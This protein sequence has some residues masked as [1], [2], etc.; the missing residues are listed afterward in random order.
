MARRYGLSEVPDDLDERPVVSYD[1]R[2]GVLVQ[3][4]PDYVGDSLFRPTDAGGGAVRGLQFGPDRKVAGGARDVYNTGRRAHALQQQQRTLDGFQSFVA[5]FNAEHPTGWIDQ[6]AGD[7][8]FAP[9]TVDADRAAN[10]LQGVEGITYLEDGGDDDA[11]SGGSSASRGLFESMMAHHRGGP[12]PQHQQQQFRQGRGPGQ[13]APTTPGPSAPFS[14]S[15]NPGSAPPPRRAMPSPPPAPQQRAQSRAGARASGIQDVDERREFMEFARHGGGA[16]AAGGVAAEYEH[17]FAPTSQGVSA[18]FVPDDFRTAPPSSAWRGIPRVDASLLPTPPPVN[19][20]TAP[21]AEQVL[22]ASRVQYNDHYHPGRGS[23]GPRQQLDTLRVQGRGAPV[24]V[25]EAAVAASVPP[26]AGL[27]GPFDDLRTYDDEW[28]ESYTPAPFGGVPSHRFEGH[29][30]RSVQEEARDAAAASP[31]TAGVAQAMNP[32]GLVPL[33]VVNDKQT[34]QSMQLFMNA[35]PPPDANY[36][37]SYSNGGGSETMYLRKMGL[38]WRPEDAPQPTSVVNRIPNGPD[39]DPSVARVRADQTARA[40]LARS[41]AQQYATSFNNEGPIHPLSKMYQYMEDRQPQNKLGPFGAPIVRDTPYIVGTRSGQDARI[42]G[43]QVSLSGD[44]AADARVMPVAPSDDAGPAPLRAASSS[45]ASASAAGGARGFR[46]SLDGDADL[47]QPAGAPTGAFMPDGKDWTSHVNLDAN[48]VA[49]GLQRTDA[50]QAY[51]RTAR[52]DRSGMST[53]H[54]SAP[55]ASSLPQ[56][57]GDRVRAT[58]NDGRGARNASGSVVTKHTSQYSASGAAATVATAGGSVRRMITTEGRGTRKADGVLQGGFVAPATQGL[59]AVSTASRILPGDAGAHA[60]H[61]VSA[62]FVAS[63]A[64]GSSAPGMDGAGRRLTSY[65]RDGSRDHGVAS[66]ERTPLPVGV[67]IATGGLRRGAG[68]DRDH[69]DHAVSAQRT[70]APS[71]DRSVHVSTATVSMATARADHATR[72]DRAAAGDRGYAHDGAAS[73]ALAPTQRRDHGVASDRYAVGDRGY[74]HDGAASRALAPT[75]RRDHGV[76][77]D[78]Y[79]VGDRGYSHDGAASRA[80]AP[81]QRRDHAVATD[82][83]AHV[84]ADATRGDGAY[85][86]QTPNVYVADPRSRVDHG[87]AASRVSFASGGTGA[88]GGAVSLAHSGRANAQMADRDGA[89][90]A[91]MRTDRATGPRVDVQG[92]RDPQMEVGAAAA[93]PA[94]VMETA[95]GHGMMMNGVT[96][97]ARAS[98]EAVHAQSMAD[99]RVSNASLQLGGGEAASRMSFADPANPARAGKGAND[100]RTDRELGRT[101]QREPA[102]RHQ[103]LQ[104]AGTQMHG[105]TTAD[106]VRMPEASIALVKDERTG[107]TQTYFVRPWDLW[108]SSSVR[109]TGDGTYV[110]AQRSEAERSAEIPRALSEADVSDA[111]SVMSALGTVGNIRS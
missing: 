55:A 18:G 52:A 17:S 110:V 61:S 16:E 88:E 86:Q 44:R 111:A 76:A 8:R 68:P 21:A 42:P 94:V 108:R 38:R 56:S 69:V 46:V 59:V 7:P 13:G 84:T 93:R 51:E 78:R 49:P 29:A 6:T 102:R 32:F 37:E 63:A 71:G 103:S 10:P 75:Q 92:R 90:R 5:G 98:V 25:D 36:A 62:D 35:P 45:G 81:T 47:S 104:A 89:S 66:G 64:A 74:S 22:D 107:V 87:V 95:A 97:D 27:G 28:A 48:T 79:A 11:Y 41:Q 72:S 2:G 65:G 109:R 24:H 105:V 99:V 14:Q 101:I 50:K 106:A 39:E 4:E 43:M 58:R 100:P 20:F 96:Q 1:D 26:N 60:D 23:S 85:A 33:G 34:G 15:Y 67:S 70:S 53:D 54:V 31:A 12:G 82:R 80:L 91:T 83:V 9:Y 40:R 57:D 19:Y 73:R 3:P 77:S 30:M